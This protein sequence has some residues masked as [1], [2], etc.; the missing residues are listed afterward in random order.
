MS[1]A[2]QMKESILAAGIKT[3]DSNVFSVGSKTIFSWLTHSAKQCVLGLQTF[4]PSC[5]HKVKNGLKKLRRASCV[6]DLQHR[7]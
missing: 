5:E 2:L 1:N 3:V 7:V 6:G 4:S